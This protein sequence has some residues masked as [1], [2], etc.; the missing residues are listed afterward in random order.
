MAFVNAFP[1]LVY[2]KVMRYTLLKPGIQSIIHTLHWVR[3]GRTWYKIFDDVHMGQGIN[4]GGLRGVGFDSAETGEGVGAVD[5]HRAASAN[6][7]PTRSPESQRRVQLVLDLDQTI[8]HHRTASVEINC[9]D[10]KIR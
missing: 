10:K 6:P 4:L 8:Q 2:N 5:V 1:G 7:L 9:N 3:L